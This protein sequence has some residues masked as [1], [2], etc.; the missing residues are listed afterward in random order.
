MLD[1]TVSSLVAQVVL[2][3]RLGDCFFGVQL[4]STESWT[5]RYRVYAV[6]MKNIPITTLLVVITLSQVTLEIVLISMQAKLG[7]KP[8]SSGVR[9]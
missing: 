4:F 2:T 3:V 1:Y 6:S 8:D 5:F 9:H 7:G